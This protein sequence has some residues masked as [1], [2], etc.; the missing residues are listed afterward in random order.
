MHSRKLD[1]D[2]AHLSS[3]PGQLGT[4]LKSA[5]RNFTGMSGALRLRIYGKDVLVD[6]E[7]QFEYLA[8]LGGSGGQADWAAAPAPRMWLIQPTIRQLAV[9]E[10]LFSQ[11]DQSLCRAWRLW[12]L[13]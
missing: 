1:V 9:P 11:N 4:D 10:G 13:F 2:T 7:E 8:L 6:L 5:S 3:Q 12:L